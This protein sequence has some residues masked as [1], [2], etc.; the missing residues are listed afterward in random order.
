VLIR[1]GILFFASLAACT[2]AIT[3]TNVRDGTEVAGTHHVW[4]Q[5]IEIVLPSGERCEGRYQTLTTKT[6]GEESL[7]YRSHVATLLG[8]NTAERFHGYA[9]LI[10]EQGTV[11]ELVFS[12]G[13]TGNGFGLAKASSGEEY[14]VTF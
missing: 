2:H 4:R 13:W 1:L 3:L 12:S 7:F 10:G 9:R 14:R 5:S 8:R 11:V 6:I